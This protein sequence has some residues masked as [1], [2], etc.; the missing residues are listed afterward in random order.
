MSERSD[1]KKGSANRR[2]LWCLLLA[3]VCVIWPSAAMPQLADQPSVMLEVVRWAE[4]GEET[5]VSITWVNTDSTFEVGGFDILIAY[6]GEALNL[7]SADPGQLLVDCDW[8]YFTYRI[9]ALTPDYDLV[10]TVAIAEIN[11]GDDHPTCYADSSGELVRLR[12]LVTE[13]Q[14]WDCQWAQLRLYWADCGDNVFASKGGE[15]LFVSRDVYDYDWASAIY[16]QINEDSPLPTYLGAPDDCVSPLAIRMIDFYNGGVDI[17]CAESLDYR[18]DVNLNGVAYEPADVVLF[19]NYFLYGLDVFVIDP[20]TQ[21]EATD[22]NADGIYL[23]LDDLVYLWRVCIGDAVPF[24]RPSTDTAVFTQDVA[25]KTVGVA[26][27]ESLTAAYL[28]FRG[29]IVPTC[30]VGALDMSYNFDGAYTRV[31]AF[32]N[33]FGSDPPIFSPGPLLTYT[34]I[35]VLKEAYTSDYGLD[36]IPTEIEVLANLEAKTDVEP[37]TMFAYW[38]HAIDPV[39][40]ATYLGN[41]DGPSVTDIDASTIRIN[42]V[43]EPISTQILPGRP[44]YTGEVMEVTFSASAMVLGY[45][46]FYDVT[47]VLYSVSGQFIDLS[48]FTVF[49]DVTM[50]GHI[51]GDVNADGAINVVDVTYLVEFL[52]FGGPPPPD[53]QTADLNHSGTVEIADLTL[54][55]ELLF[56]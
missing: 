15:S 35:G 10:R 49:G 27:P 56:G 51:M 9:S 36:L 38:A 44:G 11:N 41:F 29:S 55:V 12:F 39:I 32:P 43:I 48:P 42:D 52:F 17:I 33:I 13:D 5:E 1:S 26:Y 2:A 16:V 37:T 45:L 22:A 50:I 7:Q 34:G 19:M 53:I 28:V 30:L 46:P 24:P 47:S 6:E 31:L 40:G 3:C 21:T 54:L 4:L 14:S 8:E 18:G 23:T 20:A 25:T